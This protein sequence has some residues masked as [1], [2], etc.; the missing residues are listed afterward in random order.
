MLSV[1]HTFAA[2]LPPLLFQQVNLFS[3]SAVVNFCRT[4]RAPSTVLG[5]FAEALNYVEF[6]FSLASVDVN[7]SIATILH[8]AQNVRC[9]AFSFHPTCL[10]FVTQLL[11][12][13]QNYLPSHVLA[14]F[15]HMEITTLPLSVHAICCM[16]IFSLC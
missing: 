16:A 2:V 5:S 15:L 9:I 3:D 1:C 11:N 4:L 10:L 12:F 14:L 6:S 8:C 7:Y 13:V